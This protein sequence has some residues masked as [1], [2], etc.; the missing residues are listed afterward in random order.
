[1]GTFNWDQLMSSGLS[2]TDSPQP[3]KSVNDQATLMPNNEHRLF[4]KSV[5][6]LIQTS[7]T[8]SGAF[9]LGEFF[10]FPAAFIEDEDIIDSVADQSKPS[11]DTEKNTM[12]AFMY[13][14]YLSSSNLVFQPNTRRMR[15]RSLNKQDIRNKNRKG[16]YF[17]NLNLCNLISKLKKTERDF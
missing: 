10:I 14:I 13:N 2:P 3:N 1:M 17:H 6:N 5:R 8:K 4:I 12:L 16:Q 9:T 11:P 7:M 15:I